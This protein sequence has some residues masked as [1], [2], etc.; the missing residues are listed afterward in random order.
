MK[1]GEVRGA[2]HNPQH[3]SA[4]MMRGATFSFSLAPLWVGLVLTFFPWSTD[5]SK[6]YSQLSSCPDSCEKLGPNPAN[7]T[8]L[9]HVKQLGTC[10]GT[11]L[12]DLSVSNDLES[13]HVPTLIRAC[14]AP[15]AGLQGEQQQG[16]NCGIANS[17]SLVLNLAWKGGRNDLSRLL[18]PL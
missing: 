8:V 6:F 12:F 10:N 18:S 16:S 11:M 17:T 13:S 9:Q 5:A 2:H 4:S 3:S 14:A 7:W 15:A 1:E